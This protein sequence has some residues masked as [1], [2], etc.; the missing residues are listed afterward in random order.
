M[1]KDYEA[2]KQNFYQCDQTAT[3]LGHEYKKLYLLELSP[4][5]SQE[6]VQRQKEKV[7]SVSGQLRSMVVKHVHDWE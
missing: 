6:Q 7:E 2:D 4:N 3:Q 1:A 5:I